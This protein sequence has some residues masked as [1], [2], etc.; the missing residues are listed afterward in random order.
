MDLSPGTLTDPCNFPPGATLKI[1]CV[2]PLVVLMIERRCIGCGHL[3]L[4]TNT[5]TFNHEYN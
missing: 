4:A 3:V 5:T 1:K 2:L